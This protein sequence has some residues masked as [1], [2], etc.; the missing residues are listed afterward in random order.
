MTDIPQ[1]EPNL[2]VMPT[3]MSANIATSVNLTCSAEGYPPPTYQ[4]FK[5]GELLPGET[6]RFLYIREVLPSE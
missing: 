6:K 2:V 1:T 3:S 5:D 4:W